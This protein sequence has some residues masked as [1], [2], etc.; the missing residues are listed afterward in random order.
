MKFSVKLPQLS[1]KQRILAMAAGGGLGVLVAVAGVSSVFVSRSQAIAR[2]V[3]VEEARLSQD[4]RVKRSKSSMEAAYAKLKT[5]FFTVDG[6]DEG[7]AVARL[8]AEIEET[9]K[10]SGG[11]IVNLSP[12]DDTVSDEWATTYH[13]DV[14]MEMTFTQLLSFMRA[15]ESR[16]LLIAIESYSVTSKDDAGSQIRF[17]ATLGL[18]VPL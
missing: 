3:K 14:R 12:K 6:M 5:Y 1:H 17:E 7:R 11:S 18:T 15:I 10:I 13:A 4:L 16:P 2:I 8:L 9:A